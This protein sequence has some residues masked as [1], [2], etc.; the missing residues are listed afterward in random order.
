[1]TWAEL[2][3]RPTPFDADA[4][5]TRI[6][7]TLLTASRLVVAG[8]PHRLIEV[9]VYYHGPEHE[10]PF[11]HRDPVQ[12]RRIEADLRRVVEHASADGAALPDVRHAADRWTA[13]EPGGERGGEAAGSEDQAL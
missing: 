3:R 5:F 12:Q 8:Q 2:F 13:R 1:M 6:A 10:D 9:E 7:T 11:A 4:W